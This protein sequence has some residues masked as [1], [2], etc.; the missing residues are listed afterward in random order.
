MTGREI[1]QNESDQRHRYPKEPK[2]TAIREKQDN[3]HES[4]N[5]PY[6]SYAVELGKSHQDENNESKLS[7]GEIVFT[8]TKFIGEPRYVTPILNIIF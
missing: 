7:T 8:R 6:A 3:N 4:N 1:F 2:L 5:M